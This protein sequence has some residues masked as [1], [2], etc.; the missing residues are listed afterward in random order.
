M[1]IKWHAVHRQPLWLII[2]GIIAPLLL[3][4]LLLRG[5][6]HGNNEKLDIFLQLKKCCFVPPPPFRPQFNLLGPLVTWSGLREDSSAPPEIS[7]WTSTVHQWKTRRGTILLL[8]YS[9]EPPKNDCRSPLAPSSL[10]SWQIVADVDPIEINGAHGIKSMSILT[11]FRGVSGS[12]SFRHS[13]MKNRCRWWSLGE[14]I[15]E[16]SV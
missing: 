1:T 13:H 9:E 8:R 14:N 15:D 2:M 6:G 7:F 3:F 11:Q 10:G 5:R 16:H 4:T 12:Q